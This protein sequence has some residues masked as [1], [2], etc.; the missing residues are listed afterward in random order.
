MLTKTNQYKPEA[1]T[2]FKILTIIRSFSG[3]SF[4]I[5]LQ[6]ITSLWKKTCSTFACVIIMFLM[7][8]AHYPCTKCSMQPHRTTGREGEC[9]CSGG[10]D[11]LPFPVLTQ[12]RL[13]TLGKVHVGNRKLAHHHK[14]RQISCFN[15]MTVFTKPY[16]FSGRKCR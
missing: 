9:I 8:M 7:I 16:C 4:C 1:G 2:I 13:S 5:S 12:I 3:M 14:T 10:R 15:L 11:G 6:S